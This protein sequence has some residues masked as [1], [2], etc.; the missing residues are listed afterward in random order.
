MMIGWSGFFVVTNATELKGQERKADVDHV[1]S[2]FPGGDGR[3]TAGA[4]VHG[5]WNFLHAIILFDEGG[6]GDGFGV[7]G[8]IMLGELADDGFVAG[9]KTRGGIEDFLAGDEANKI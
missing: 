2:T 1:V 4:S 9:A 7:F 5:D 8:G 6:G 3:G